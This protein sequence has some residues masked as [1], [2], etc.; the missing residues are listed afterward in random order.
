M[1]PSRPYVDQESYKLLA[2]KATLNQGTVDIFFR[3]FCNI[4]HHNFQIYS[5]FRKYILQILLICGFLKKSFIMNAPLVSCFQVILFWRVCC[6]THPKRITG[7]GHLTR[8]AFI[9]N[10]LLRNP[11]F[12][13][14]CFLTVGNLAQ[15][16]DLVCFFNF[17]LFGRSNNVV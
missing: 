6:C 12:S 3:T 15:L 7:N 8:G 4:F 14:E 17:L 2:N 5:E 10:D 11:H 13:D 1:T 9:I 16:I